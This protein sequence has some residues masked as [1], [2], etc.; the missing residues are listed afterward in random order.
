MSDTSGGNEVLLV[1]VA[2]QNADQ[3]VPLADGKGAVAVAVQAAQTVAIEASYSS[4]LASLS[5]DIFTLEWEFVEA[6]A[7]SGLELSGQPSA[8]GD[9]VLTAT[10]TGGTDL[11]YYWFH[12]EQPVDG[13]N[14]ATLALSSLSSSD[15]GRYHVVAKD[16]GGLARSEVIEVSGPGLG[17]KFTTQP[18]GG[19]FN[20]GETIVLSAE[21]EGEGAVT[22]QWR[23]HGLG[24]EGETASSFTISPVAMRDADIYDVVVTDAAGS[25]ASKAVRVS[26]S[27][28][29]RLNALRFRSDRNVV[30]EKPGAQAEAV[31]AA[32]GG[33]YWAAGTFSRLGDVSVGRVIKVTSEGHLDG[34]FA[35]ATDF[36]GEIGGLID[37][38]E[39]GVW[40]WG[41]IGS[42]VGTSKEGELRRYNATGQLVQSVAMSSLVE[43][44]RSIR[45]VVQDG[46]GRLYILF[47]RESDRLMRRLSKSGAP[48]TAYAPP[49]TSTINVVDIVATMDGTVFGHTNKM[50]RRITP[51]GEWDSNFAF[52]LGA[53]NFVIGMAAADMDQVVVF[54][55]TNAH[56]DYVGQPLQWIRF[57][58]DG[59]EILGSAGAANLRGT[60]DDLRRVRSFWAD[61]AGEILVS[62]VTMR[63]GFFEGKLW[64]IKSGGAVEVEQVLRFGNEA[65]RS[66]IKWEWY[67]SI[68]AVGADGGV[69]L[70]GAY[71]YVKETEAASL[72]V[73]KPDGIVVAVTDS[74]WSPGQVNAL[75]P[76]D[77]GGLVVA[78]RFE[79]INGKSAVSLARLDAAGTLDQ[80]FAAFGQPLASV[81]TVWRDGTGRWLIMG[82]HE[83]GTTDSGITRARLLPNGMPDPDFN[84][85]ELNL[86]APPVIGLSGGRTLQASYSS[87]GRMELNWLAEDGAS[88][89][90]RSASDF[91]RFFDL[92]ETVDGAVVRAGLSA[93]SVGG[94]LAD[95]FHEGLSTNLMFGYGQLSPIYGYGFR[96]ISLALGGLM[97]P[98]EDYVTFESNFAVKRDTWGRVDPSFVTAGH[99]SA[100]NEHYAAA[101]LTNGEIQLA[102]RIYAGASGT[103]NSFVDTI[104]WARILADG[105]LDPA[106][107][108]RDL[109]TSVTALL[110]RDDGNFYVATDGRVRLTEEMPGSELPAIVQSPQD[111][112]AVVGEQVNFFANATGIPDPSY[113]WFKDSVAINDATAAMLDLGVV[114]VTDAGIYHVVATNASG[115]ATSATAILTVESLGVA[116]IINS[117]PSGVAATIAPGVA[118]SVNFSVVATGDPVPT[119]QWRKNGT[120]IDGAT[121]SSLMLAD[122]SIEDS[123]SSFDVL[124]SNRLGTVTSTAAVLTV[125]EILEAP[126]ISIQPTG[127]ALRFGQA[128]GA[129]VVATG[130]APLSYQWTKDGLAIAGATAVSIDLPFVTLVDAGIYA[131]TVTNLAGSVTSVGAVLSV[132]PASAE[133]VITAQP[134]NTSALVGATA[135]L[136]VSVTG[137]PS[138]TFQWR[139]NGV[140]LAGANASVLNFENV[141]LSAAGAYDVLVTNSQGSVTSIR[142]RLT[143]SAS[144]I[145][146][147]ITSQPRDTIAATGQSTTL[148]VVATGVP[149]LTYQWMKNGFPISGA[150]AADLMFRTVSIQDAGS[151]AVVVTNAEGTVTS[152]NARLKV[153]LASYQGTYFGSF[154]PGRGAFA[155]VVEADNTGF[156]LGF[157]EIANLY[158]SGTVTVADDGS[159]TL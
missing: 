80:E 13:A 116:P 113:Q 141:A 65:Q 56:P 143:V 136:N 95:R 75:V 133:P 18:T 16:R 93:A 4:N 2:G 71:R 146:P 92:S 115:T 23:R 34:T 155:I 117:H 83:D 159:F 99:W 54:G 57:S 43:G 139:K 105:S 29:R 85:Y 106:A 91:Y 90:T 108:L 89:T 119:Y 19:V 30:V 110:Q 67:D 33:G 60:H 152:R 32:T 135:T 35:A 76:D 130:T 153:L 25:L 68:F 59:S 5:D 9:V 142:V 78:G 123:G 84:T 140:A 100:S 61:S 151:Y 154:G 132:E 51:A 48:D 128:F 17:P 53:W 11:S 144:N 129:S 87:F 27:P 121:A 46:T 96:R 101:A 63:N 37:D 82:Y 145:A 72:A 104:H 103:A 12:N 118:H 10:A 124:V 137:T 120:P 111:T 158:V 79:L 3:L 70:G 55:N 114:A 98:E 150:T 69:L 148:S 64:R 73:L 14:V 44:A 66:T 52:D 77:A 88:E 1:A 6:P 49:A 81:K 131:V 62:G 41:N 40:L 109:D 134:R 102:G 15:A 36:S 7:L 156:F 112:S 47:D 157:D 42:Y 58:A 50:L 94:S 74:L 8:G 21:A 86:G 26:V 127:A 39:G 20:A 45:D 28:A 122:V 38:G 107:T 31:A 22:F 149:D 138:P 125:T 147:N 126:M 97:T 24:L